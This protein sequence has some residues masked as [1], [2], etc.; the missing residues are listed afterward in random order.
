MA[1][2]FFIHWTLS[3]Q[4]LKL[5]CFDRDECRLE[6]EFSDG[7]TAIDR[8]NQGASGFVPGFVVGKRVGQTAIIPGH[9]LVF[10]VQNMVK[11]ELRCEKRMRIFERI[12]DAGAWRRRG[13]G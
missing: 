12:N 11:I 5:A 4:R 10:R 6:N 2:A 9:R 3:A 7:L 8:F 13:Q 1:E